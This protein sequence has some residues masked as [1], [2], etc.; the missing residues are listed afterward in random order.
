MKKVYALMGLTAAMTLSASAGILSE[1][2][3]GLNKAEWTLEST[4]DLKVDFSAITESPLKAAK[5]E[6]TRASVPGGLEGVYSL[7]WVDA[8]NGMFLD[9]GFEILLNAD[10]KTGQMV[11]LNGLANLK[12]EVDAAAGTI[13]IPN[14]QVGPT[15]SWS[16]TDPD[17]NPIT[18]N[19]TPMFRHYIVNA[20]RMLE[21]VD[22]PLV[23]E[24]QGDGNFVPKYGN[25]DVFRECAPLENHPDL[26]LTYSKPPCFGYV[27]QLYKF[28]ETLDNTGWENIGEATIVDNFLTEN[29]SW[30]CPVQRSTT[31]DG[32]YRLV[33][34]YG[35]KFSDVKYLA[36]GEIRFDVSCPTAPMIMFGR[37]LYNGVFV[38][39]V[40]PEYGWTADSP[41][42]YFFGLSTYVSAFYYAQD[43][44][45]DEVF[46]KEELG[47]EFGEDECGSVKGDVITFA[48]LVDSISINMGLFNWEDS[49]QELYNKKFIITM[50]EG[51][52]AGVND[53]L[54]DN[55]NAPVKYYNL[56]GMEV[57]NPEAGQLVIKKQ[58]NKVVKMIAE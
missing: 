53:I 54:V 43:F 14:Q 29:G 3:A 42:G 28:P 26:I 11:T 33:D 19:V 34:P 12:I 30:S 1:R 25:A 46:T 44:E 22:E 23:F 58:G 9:G 37:K 50:P 15:E 21:A 2:H 47:E 10:G 56:Q 35:G 4:K 48:G 20:D 40:A 8:T 49:S 39:E 32:V 16:G 24:Y 18:D 55:T 51:W 38:E 5:A 41:F 6:G 27:M 36:E 13:S 57:N 45:S 31:E 7:E 52:S 17:G